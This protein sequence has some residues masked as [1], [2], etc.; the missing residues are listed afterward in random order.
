MIKSFFKRTVA[1]VCALVI[2]IC[3]FSFVTPTFAE[4]ASYKPSKVKSLKASAGTTYVTLSWDKVSDADAYAVFSY[5]PKTEKYKVLKNT[6]DTSYKVKNLN[7]A[8]TY[9]FAVQAYNS[10]GDKRYYGEV[11]KNVKVKTKS[12]TPTQVKNLNAAT[13]N[14]TSIKLKWTKIADAKYVIYSYNSKSEKYTKLGT[15]SG[16]SYTAKNLKANTDYIFAVRAYKT[17]NGK[18]HYGK[19]SE[20]LSVTTAPK[21]ITLKEAR[22]LFK[23]ARKVYMDWVY[24]CNYIS[25]EHTVTHEFYGLSCQFA[26]VEHSTV[27]EKDD[28]INLLDRYFTKDVYENELYLYVELNG[29]LYGKLYYYAEGGKSDAD[30]ITRYYTDKLT[31]LSGTKFQYTLY[32]VY[33]DSVNSG[34][35]PKS[36]TYN[37]IRQGDSWVFSDTFHPCAAPI[38]ED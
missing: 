2:L 8:T 26:A 20:K 13:I 31:K 17:V 35:L 4:A 14:A 10:N 12:A 34:K 28:I 30:T 33:Y 16:N 36:Y 23:D 7:A 15:A 18:N 19:Y 5:N 38:K 9:Y 27:K 32:P 3:A 1:S 21:A 11:S 24:S 37:I 6:D 25:Y 22:N 29:K